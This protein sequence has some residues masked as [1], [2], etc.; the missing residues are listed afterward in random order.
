ML[1]GIEEVNRVT[2]THHEDVEV[3]KEADVLTKSCKT[4]KSQ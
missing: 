4:A 3:V 2:K 1:I